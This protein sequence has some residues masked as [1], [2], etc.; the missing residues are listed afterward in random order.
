[1]VSNYKEC[2]IP[3]HFFPFIKETVYY[4]K[5]DEG[6]DIYNKIGF[7]KKIFIDLGSKLHLCR[8]TYVEVEDYGKKFYFVR[9]SDERVITSVINVLNPGG[10]SRQTKPTEKESGASTTKPQIL[11]SSTQ[12]LAAEEKEMTIFASPT[13]LEALKK[14]VDGLHA[15]KWLKI[16]SKFQGAEAIT[17]FADQEKVKDLIG[18]FAQI[19]RGTL[20]SKEKADEYSTQIKKFKNELKKLIEELNLKEEVNDTIDEEIEAL[21]KQKEG[22]EETLERYNNMLSNDVVKDLQK[23]SESKNKFQRRLLM[24]KV[25]KDIPEFLLKPVEELSDT[26]KIELQAF[27]GVKASTEKTLAEIEPKKE[28]IQR[29]FEERKQKRVEE[30]AQAKAAIYKALEENGLKFETQ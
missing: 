23:L 6:I 4:K 14:E 24:K 25:P 9:V 7:L 26:Q 16:A 12:A 20:L 21:D 22:L 11:S 5:N 30:I 28:A 15:S 3:N 17:Q 13:E 27:M 10:S 2:S 19:L 18:I 29:R 8:K 1:M